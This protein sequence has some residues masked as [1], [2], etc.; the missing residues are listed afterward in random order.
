MT[1]CF[2]LGK[3][4][5]VEFKRSRVFSFFFL[6]FHCFVNNS[7]DGHLRFNQS[8]LSDLDPLHTHFP[9]IV[10]CLVWGLLGVEAR[11]D[12][13]YKQT[14]LLL[15]WLMSSVSQCDGT[16][17]TAFAAVEYVANPSRLQVTFPQYV[18]N[19]LIG[20]IFCS[21]FLF[22]CLVGRCCCCCVAP[23]KL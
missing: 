19:T 20:L 17:W 5:H 11:Q 10:V 13:D 23:P 8:G 6:S 16:L 3:T 4:F 7:I 2:V 18:E 22:F 1:Q 12:G 9:V 15:E 21:F 14:I